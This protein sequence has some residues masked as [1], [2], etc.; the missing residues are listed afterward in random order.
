MRDFVC[1]VVFDKNVILMSLLADDWYNLLR[2]SPVRQE[3]AGQPL[4]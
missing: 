3:G 4:L 2:V 1:F